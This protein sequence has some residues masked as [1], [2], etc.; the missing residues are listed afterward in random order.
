MVVTNTVRRRD[1]QGSA[2]VNV[3]PERWFRFYLGLVQTFLRVRSC[4]RFL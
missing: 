2:R 4:F 1:Q 3:G